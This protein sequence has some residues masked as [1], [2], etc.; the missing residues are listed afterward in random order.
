MDSPIKYLNQLEADLDAVAETKTVKGRGGGRGG[1]A[2]GGRWKT[3]S[4]AA[5]AFLVLAWG[6]GFLADAGLNDG[7]F[8]LAGVDAGSATQAGTGTNDEAVP[9]ASPALLPVAEEA[10]LPWT[11][12]GDTT[13]DRTISIGKT[14]IADLSKIVRDG[15]LSIKIAN[16][17]FERRF[18]DVT[19]IAEAYGGYVLES[20]TKGAGSG[21][22]T[23]R[24]PAA[25]F[26]DAIVAVR[27]LGEVSASQMSGEDVTAEYVD[28]QARLTILEARR[29]VL[30]SLMTQATTIPQTITV[31]NA[32]DGVQL[33]IEQIQGQ[34]RFFDKQVAE[35]TLKVELREEGVEEELTQEEE[36][37]GNPSLSRAVDRAI[38][39]FFGVLATVIVGLGYLVPLGVLGGLGYGAVMLARRRRR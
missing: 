18:E 29:D 16:G 31:Q 5:A 3:W 33:K 36:E 23:L 20:E 34:L 27:A 6:I 21:S 11:A 30:L 14:Q 9:A 35:S 13:T 25:R 28:L 22:L 1:R 19:D 10:F 26:D 39:G 24:I 4:G 32:L 8:S 17:T 12:A 2:R 37:I 15:S 38:Q 7:S